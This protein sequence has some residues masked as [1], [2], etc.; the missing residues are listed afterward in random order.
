MARQWYLLVERTTVHSECGTPRLESASITFMA[1]AFTKQASKGRWMISPNPIGEVQIINGIEEGLMSLFR[2]LSQL[3]SQ[4][5]SLKCNCTI[6]AA[7]RRLACRHPRG[8]W[9]LPFL[10]SVAID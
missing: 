6:A 10:S 8:W 7:A 5:M 4:V 3:R 9:H 2:Y 1:M